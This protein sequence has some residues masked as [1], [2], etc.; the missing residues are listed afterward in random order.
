MADLPSSSASKSTATQSAGANTGLGGWIRHAV[1]RRIRSYWRAVLQDILTVALA[2]ETVG[3]LRFLDRSPFPLSTVIQLAGPSLL[4]GVMYAIIS[5]AYGIH[6][7]LWRYGSL[8]ELK[9]LL[10]AELTLV[11]FVAAL[12][13]LRVYPFSTVP[14][15]VALGGLLLFPP[16]LAGIKIL[17]RLYHSLVAAHTPA[18]VA[19]PRTRVLIAGA[20]QAAATLSQRLLA[21]GANGYEVVG[22]VDDD[23]SKWNRGLSG[24]PVFGPI[25]WI[26]D[27]VARNSVEMV[28][29]A[30]PSAGP[31][32]ISEIIALCQ[33]TNVNIKIQ[34]SLHD[35]FGVNAQSGYLRDVDVADLIGRDVVALESDDTARLISGKTVLVT[36][37]A[38]SIG[39]ELCRQVARLRPQRLIALDNNETGLFDLVEG[40]IRDGIPRETLVS[41]IG[42]ITD[43]DALDEI[44][45]Q[46]RPDVVFH[47]AAY[48]HVPL[49]EE[50]PRQA[51][52]TNVL[53]TYYLCRAAQLYGVSRFIFISSDKAAD[54]VNVLGESK[55]MGEL[56][57]QSMSQA[58]ATKK[59]LFSAV[60][61]GNV[62]GSRGSVV[63]TFER[64]IAAGGPV[65][66]TDPGVTR[67]FM[68]IPEA[69]GLVLL[70]A[71]MADQSSLFL[72]DMG[73]PVKIAD[74]A[75]KMI[76][77]KGL[78]IN[79]D[80]ALVFTGLRPGEKMHEALTATGEHLERTRF[81]KILQVVDMPN[82]PT[83]ELL[84]Q[85][86]GEFAEKAAQV[87]APALRTLMTT[88]VS[89]YSAARTPAS[90]VEQ[91]ASMRA[92]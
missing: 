87:D 60:R 40:L 30:L 9:Q 67:Y 76:R 78:R 26:P 24:K 57:V 71:T 53:G 11:P 2:F 59:T 63:P 39:S 73:E 46:A 14:R 81:P 8:R 42:D 18:P 65:T 55:R 83:P 23:E 10:M 66:V 69:C 29:I 52:R 92:R 82:P 4:I 70:S 45:R 36:G 84:T 75:T 61:F 56:I 79:Q 44:F 1:I 21:S 62:I 51:A 22:Y 31:E 38:G 17:P 89:E 43:A 48:K 15:S 3:A 12:V 28:A 85:W 25:E 6:R 91:S 32:R 54:P 5:Y 33:T 49:L 72:L 88:C 16:Y 34:P 58:D 37:A 90:A 13:L 20:G 35:T 64:Q 7:R 77:L 68:T 80:I 19:E 41:R 27:I 47:A 74:L 86:M 50:H